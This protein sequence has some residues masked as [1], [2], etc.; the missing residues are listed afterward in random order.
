MAQISIGAIFPWLRSFA[1]R[2]DGKRS[3]IEQALADL[4]CQLWRGAGVAVPEPDRAG[5]AWLI[6]GQVVL[7]AGLLSAILMLLLGLGVFVLISVDRPDA[8]AVPLLASSI[9]A[10]GSLLVLPGV[11]MIDHGR[12][13]LVQVPLDLSTGVVSARYPGAG[14]LLKLA[15]VALGGLALAVAIASAV[16]VI[17][18]EPSARLRLPMLPALPMPIAGALAILTLGTGLVVGGIALHRRG[19]AML[20]PSA[21]ELRAADRR[22]PVVLLRS[23]GDEDLS[24]VAVRTH[25]H[26]VRLARLEE[27]IADRLRL[28]GPLVAIGSP[29]E[30]LPTLGAARSYHSDMEWRWAVGGL[31]REALLIVM[32]AGLTAGLRWEIEAIVR[33]EHLP[34]LLILMP[35]FDRQRRWDVVLEELQDLPALAGLPRVVPDGLLCLHAGGGEWS[36]LTSSSDW[37]ADYEEA[38][39]LAV[40]GI[41]CR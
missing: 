1:D 6:G 33:E 17:V 2:H 18:A 21:D 9:A 37:E 23:F 11:A 26:A 30:A 39:D 29:G 8:A 5:S 10:L 41:C 14:R 35:A 25:G 27:A 4:S 40:Y 13:L 20:Q 22:R 16:V 15:G 32:V 28:F 19:Q 24:V 12:R 3:E 36:M 7:A 38:I 34:K 31:M